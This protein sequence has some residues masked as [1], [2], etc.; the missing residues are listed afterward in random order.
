MKTA[1]FSFQATCHA[2]HA[3]SVV[4]GAETKLV[5]KISVKVKNSAGD[6]AEHA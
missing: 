2:P 5:M 6:Q 3:A 1:A 4:R